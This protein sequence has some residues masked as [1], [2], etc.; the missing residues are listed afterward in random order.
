[1]FAVAQKQCV[2]E[3]VLTACSL[4]LQVT[5]SLIFGLSK[6]TW[7]QLVNS[8]SYVLQCPKGACTDLL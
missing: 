5:A 1:M 7:H 4:R 3:V 8:I 6:H 2:L